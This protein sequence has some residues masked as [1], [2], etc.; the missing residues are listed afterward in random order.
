MFFFSQKT[1][2]MLLCRATWCNLTQITNIWLLYCIPVCLNVILWTV[3]KR[4]WM[5]S[6]FKAWGN[7]QD[8][9]RPVN[10][11]YSLRVLWLS[12]DCPWG[13]SAAFD[14]QH[15][16]LLF[17]LH[18]LWLSLSTGSAV[19]SHCVSQLAFT[20]AHASRWTRRHHHETR[21][22]S[23]D[24]SRHLRRRSFTKASAGVTL[25]WNS[26]WTFCWPCTKRWGWCRNSQKPC[27]CQCSRGQGRNWGDQ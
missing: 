21:I 8:C 22:P 24:S 18:T 2:Y 4:W 3:L 6:C 13:L 12:I 11:S 9:L 14:Q 17:L 10:K 1:K 19:L 7:W 25:P 26:F 15:A 16:A 5:Q 27:W 23:S 20:Q